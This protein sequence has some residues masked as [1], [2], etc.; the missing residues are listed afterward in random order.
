MTL[1]D[2]CQPLDRLI[3]EGGQL[4]AH[5]PERHARAVVTLFL[6]FVYKATGPTTVET[7]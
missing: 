2:Y 5:L 7:I 6:A 1:T 3:D 4:V